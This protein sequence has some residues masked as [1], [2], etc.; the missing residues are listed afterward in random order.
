MRDLFEYGVI[1][2]IWDIFKT[3]KTKQVIPKDA[4]LLFDLLGVKSSLKREE[5]MAFFIQISDSCKSVKEFEDYLLEEKIP[6]GFQGSVVDMSFHFRPVSHLKLSF[7][8]KKE[9]I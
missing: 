3:M 8:K 2:R 4:Y 5:L 9:I 6:S 1:E 7:W